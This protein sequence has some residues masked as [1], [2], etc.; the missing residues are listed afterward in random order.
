MDEAAGDTISADDMPD[1]FTILPDMQAYRRIISALG[2]HEPSRALRALKDMVEA[3]AGATLGWLREA[4]GSKVFSRGFLRQSETYFAW[5]NAET[6]LDG[7]EFEEVG[8]L[9]EQL[10]IRVATGSFSLRYRDNAPVVLSYTCG[11]TLFGFV[12]T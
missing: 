8:A 11:D 6:I 5:K 12:R 9:S 2:P 4:K 3:G 1:Y 10:H 7:E